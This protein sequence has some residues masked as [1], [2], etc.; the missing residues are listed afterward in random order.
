MN[1]LSK[2][3][4][5][6][7]KLT[8]YAFH[9]K[10]NLAREPL[11]S[12]KN[13]NYLWLK[14]QQIG[15]QLNVPELENLP[16]KIEKINNQKTSIT[17]EILPE[18]ILSFTEEENKN[19]LP[20][21][22][23]LSGE[24]NPLQIQDTYAIDLTLRYS[25]TKVNET[26]STELHPD[27]YVK[28]ADL[29][30][31]NKDNCLLPNNINSSLGQTLVFFAKTLEEF[32]DE[33]SLQ[34]FADD[35]VKALITEEKFQELQIYCQSQGQLLG[36]PIFEYN[37][38]ADSPQ[39][40]CHILI[41]LNTNPETTKHEENGEYYYP[42]IN[43]LLCRNKIKYLRHKA[44]LCN[45][46]ARKEYSLLE[47]IV[48]E[49]SQ[50]KHNIR[51]NL[52]R[53]Q[54]LLIEVPELSFDY[55]RYIRDLQAHKTT[56][57]A[58]LKNYRLQFD[59]IEKLYNQNDL[60]FLSSFSKLAQNTYIKQIN[61]DLAYLTPANNLFK[62]M[63]ETIRGMVEI[64]QAKL[65][66]ENIEREKSLEDTI[67]VVGVALGGGGIAAASISAHIDKPMIVDIKQPPHLIVSSTFWSIIATLFLAFLTRLWIKRK[68]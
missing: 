2:E 40:Q 3:K 62:Q 39:Q 54:Q 9:L 21:N 20:L 30:G 46:Q 43:L 24:V 55:A 37:N 50:I 6:N 23:I 47:K 67:Q 51:N 11:T 42:L 16:T 48:N 56:I 44:I 66:E 33:E 7:P 14:C 22:L 60:E 10:D 15:Q 25:N 27:N 32:E 36:S 57:E 38:D 58:S 31:L 5:A 8:L 4:L 13:T 68:I 17:G 26:H 34:N 29:K 59:K 64:E 18:G 28:V 41:W 63:T 49:F 12:V 45:Q 53:L 52:Q 35:C 1:Y 61:T 19:N 65:E